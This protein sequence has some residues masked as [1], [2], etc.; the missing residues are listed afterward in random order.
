VTVANVGDVPG[1]EKSVKVV[2][3]VTARA[4][5]DLDS[6]AL[7]I[8]ASSSDTLGD[9]KLSAKGFGHIGSDGALSLDA[10][11]V[12]ADVTGTSAAGRRRA[13]PPRRPIPTQRS[14]SR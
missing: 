13:S 14:P 2:D 7:T 6:H 12:P 3:K 1:T 11:G 4:V 10:N 5:Y 9:P 8:D